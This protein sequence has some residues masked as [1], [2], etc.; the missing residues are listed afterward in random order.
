MVTES[1]FIPRTPAFMVWLCEQKRIKTD[2]LH[3]R[4]VKQV[5]GGWECEWN[6]NTKSLKPFEWA[7]YFVTDTEFDARAGG[8]PQ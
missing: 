1:R 2:G 3:I 8:Q 5:E 7:P 4:N 6:E